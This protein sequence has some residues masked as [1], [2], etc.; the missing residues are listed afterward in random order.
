M[1]ILHFFRQVM[2]DREASK[3]M[4]ELELYKRKEMQEIEKLR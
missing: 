2:L 1:I 3:K 4:H